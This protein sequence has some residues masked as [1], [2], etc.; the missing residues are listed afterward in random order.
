M[1]KPK[2]PAL[3][4]LPPRIDTP[5]T[6]ERIV[7]GGYGLARVLGRV[8]LVFGAAPGDIVRF[9]LDRAPG[10]TLFA[11]ITEIVVPS[12]DRISPPY[13]D[14]TRCGGADFQH[15]TY[16]A[17]LRAKAGIVAD[18]LRRVGGIELAEPIPITPSPQIWG[19]RARADW[20]YDP[21]PPALGYL[22]HGT[23]QV[24]DLP[25]DPFV[26]TDL[27]TL[28]E[29]LRS[30]MNRGD[31]PPVGE[32]RAAASLNEASLAPPLAGGEVRPIAIEV[33]GER[34][35][36]DATVFFQA[37]PGILPDLVAE[38]LRF[39]PAAADYAAQPPDVVAVDL[40]AG[41]GL[42][43]L[44]LARRYRRVVAVEA[45][46]PTATYLTRNASE[47][48]LRGVRVVV[49]PVE[50]WLDGAYR[51]YGRPALA[52]L[53]PPRTGLPPQAASL[54]ARLRPARIAY[55][56]CDPPT[57]ARDLKRLLGGGYRLERVTGFDMF[58][59][60]HHVEVVAHLVREEREP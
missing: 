15:L 34:L 28:Y 33:A 40:Y 45:D 58:P 24:C 1:V 38:A 7:P 47:A 43:T 3:P 6:I 48:G 55:V 29:D 37:N 30:R 53:D 41:V 10:T 49:E 21:A 60:T 13:P 39:A 23:R 52:L 26:T 20:R 57:L 46:A 42:F 31:L 22:A 51:T 56:S 44:P 17:Q 11:H 16:D 18:A 50:R 5:V 36:F 27:A 9:E 19:Y 32:F 12:S 14:A 59:Q 25:F 2:R 4:P 54:L 8:V 35:W